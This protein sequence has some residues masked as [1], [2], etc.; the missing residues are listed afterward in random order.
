MAPRRAKGKRAADTDLAPVGSLLPD[1][2]L[3]VLQ[4]LPQC[5]RF[6]ASEVCRAWRDATL[7]PQ[8]WSSVKLVLPCED[9][10]AGAESFLSWLLPRAAGVE[11][12]HIDIEEAAAQ[13]NSELV[14]GVMSNL[15]AAIMATACTLRQLVIET[16]GALV[17]SQ[18]AAALGQLRSACFIGAEVHLKQ[19]LGKLP[20]LADLEFGSNAAELS[21]EAPNCLPLATTH[22]SLEHCGLSRLPACIARLTQLRSLDVSQNAFEDDYGDELRVLS[23]LTGLECLKLANCRMLQVPAELSAL[24]RLRILHMGGNLGDE[25]D[26]ADMEAV[27]ACL[28]PLRHLQVLVMS[29]CNVVLPEA[30]RRMGRLERLFVTSTPVASLPPGP[31][32]RSLRQL[33][34]DWDVVFESLPMLAQCTQLQMLTLARPHRSEE[35]LKEPDAQTPEQAD[36]LA[37]ALLAHPALKQVNVVAVQG[38]SLHLSIHTLRFVL[39]LA[40]A[41]PRLR[42]ELIESW[43]SDVVRIPGLLDLD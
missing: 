22:L 31:Y 15:T 11:S 35:D 17:V 2:L 24:R 18:W 20:H 34:L 8:L 32:C 37:A 42:V 25:Y 40:Q 26:A 41:A 1:I 38:R 4:K 7:A 28:R 27:E 23:Q 10:E 19:G 9:D 13:R 30:V 33:C 5:Q 6:R 12:L 3:L 14:V 39:A 21:I 29:Q 43:D 16:A 36:E